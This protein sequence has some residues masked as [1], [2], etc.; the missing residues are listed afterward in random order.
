MAATTQPSDINIGTTFL[1]LSWVGFAVSTPVVI[2]R[3]WVALGLVKRRLAIHDWMILCSVIFNLVSCILG[4]YAVHWGL[5]RH[6]VFLSYSQQFHAQKFTTFLEPVIITA[7]MF[8]RVS[9]AFFLL[10]IL[11]PRDKWFRV[12]LWAV[13]AIQFLQDAAIIIEL[14]TQCG[15]HTDALWD[16]HV[17]AAKDCIPLTLQTVLAY[18]SSAFNS[19]SD[20]WLSALPAIMLRGLAMA[21]STKYALAAVLCLS[22]FAFAASIVKTIENANLSAV[23]DFTYNVTKLEIWIM[24]EINIVILTASAPTI[25]PFF[26]RNRGSSAEGYYDVEAT[27]KRGFTG[28]AQS[29]ALQSKSAVSTHNQDMSARSFQGHNDSQEYVLKKLDKNEISKTT[30]VQVWYE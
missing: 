27:K 25:R 16:P 26:T 12:S 22:L 11:G 21:R 5:G 10:N 29:L 23:G 17:N 2:L 13:I 9:F 19:I 30:D 18:L 15:T 14:F 24:V 1:I 8:G 3:F 20:L 4:S 28:R 7:P 6:E